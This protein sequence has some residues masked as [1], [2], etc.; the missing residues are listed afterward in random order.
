[1][2]T[3]VVRASVTRAAPLG[4]GVRWEPVP[5]DRWRT[6]D[7]VAAEVVEASLQATVEATDGRLVEVR[8]GDIVIGALGERAATLEVVGDWREVREDLRL[9]AL[10]RGGVLGRVTSS[11]PGV[12]HLIFALAYR[13]HVVTEGAHLTM[14]SV[15]PPPPPRD[16]APC[17]PTVLIIG[18][19]M[20][21]G[22]TSSAK[23]II[24]VLNGL[25]L[26]V[27]GAKLTGVGRYADILAMADAGAEMVMDFVDAGLPS[28]IGPPAMAAAAVARITSSVGAVG[29][30]VLVAEVGASPLEPYNGAA[31]IAALGDAVRFTVLCASDPYAVVGVTQSFDLS[32][33]LIAGRATAT[34]AARRLLAQLS[35]A[36]A[37]DLMDP[38]A[39]VP[40][41]S[42]L[43]RRLGVGAG[44]GGA[45]AAA[46][47][48]VA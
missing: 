29:V 5:R 15:L 17:P 42:L 3:P 37:L 34:S 28:S 25:G 43:T 36:P 47:P 14:T 6:G 4:P 22:K 10:T 18:T 20:S 44:S 26:R 13:G 30:D 16:R 21:A 41:A 38:A 2:T 27:A 12:R 23:T 31:A 32:P 40:L 46:P 24:R 45:G 35:P 33:D 8:P 1:V 11:A 39:A 9:E 7:L 19:S 48:G